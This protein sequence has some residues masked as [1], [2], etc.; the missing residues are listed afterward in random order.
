MKKLITVVLLALSLTTIKISAQERIYYDFTYGDGVYYDL[1]TAL[2]SRMSDLPLQTARELGATKYGLL[3]ITT[4]IS[5]GSE[6][7]QYI[8]YHNSSKSSYKQTY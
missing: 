6:N 2:Q 5:Y 8:G 4:I 3:A 7:N 1:V